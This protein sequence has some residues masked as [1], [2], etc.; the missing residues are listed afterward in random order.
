MIVLRWHVQV[1]FFASLLLASCDNK[2]HT[3][4]QYP[5]MDT[6]AFA[7]FSHQCSYCHVPPLPSKHKAQEWSVVMER[8]MQH[9]AGRGLPP[10]PPRQQTEILTYLQHHAAERS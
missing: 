7:Y 4:H 9:R 1:W 5:A 6:A 3:Q 2:P 10:I 8:M